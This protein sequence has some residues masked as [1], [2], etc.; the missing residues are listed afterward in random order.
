[1]TAEEFAETVDELIAAA[2]EG[3]LSDAAT[4]CIGAI[5]ALF[6]LWPVGGRPW[7]M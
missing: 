2:R 3:G 1:M 7:M 4:A 6:R 5:A